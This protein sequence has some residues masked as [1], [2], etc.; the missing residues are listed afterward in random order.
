MIVTT[1]DA[2]EPWDGETE[3]DEVISETPA[4]AVV[5]DNAEPEGSTPVIVAPEQFE[6]AAPLVVEPPKPAAV[7]SIEEAMIL[8]DLEEAEQTEMLTE[9]EDDPNFIQQEFIFDDEIDEDD[10]EIQPEE[11][12]DAQENNND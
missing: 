10:E 4:P 1:K 5:P 2:E 11:D 3:K 8:N 7:L 9:E 12:A 6:P